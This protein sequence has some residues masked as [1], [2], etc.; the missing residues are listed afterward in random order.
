[1]LSFKQY[2]KEMALPRDEDLAKT[3]YHGTDFKHLNSLKEHGLIAPKILRPRASL[4]PQTGKVYLASNIVNALI[5]AIGGDML[6]HNVPERWL[7]SDDTRYGLLCVVDG[8]KLLDI[9]PDEDNIGEMIHDKKFS[10]LNN[11]AQNT[12]TPGS[13]KKVMEGDYASWAR[14][15]KAVLKRLNENQIFKI[16]D[17]GSN[18]AH[19]GSIEVKEFW[20]F[21]KTLNPQLKKD[22]S[23]FFKLAE[24]IK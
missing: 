5:C 10:W 19:G 14:A 12:I 8:Q 4:A 15:G 18:L 11:L 22:G 3:Y 17:A 6:G 1:M 7:Q 9:L 24:K 16:I 2:L 13:Y 21:D 23:N 20:K